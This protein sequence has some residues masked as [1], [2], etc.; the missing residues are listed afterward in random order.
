M[1][2][3]GEQNGA[4]PTAVIELIGEIS[5][6]L[7]SLERCLLTGT[8]IDFDPIT[9]LVEKLCDEARLL[10]ERD[11]PSTAVRLLGVVADCDNLVSR[12]SS[13]LESLRRSAEDQGHRERSLLTYARTAHGAR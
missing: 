4:S 8:D 5:V 11:R 10:A 9:G 6:R 13:S 7:S 12:L 1:R 2:P 3:K